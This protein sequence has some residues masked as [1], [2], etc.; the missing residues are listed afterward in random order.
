MDLRAVTGQLYLINGQR[1]T[2]DDPPGLLSLAPPSRAARGRHKDYLFIHLTLSG[3]AE[4]SKSLAEDLTDSISSRFYNA[5][6]SVTAALRKAIIETNELLL[7]QN[8]SGSGDN[9]EGA[10]IC[11]VLRENELFMAQTGEAF[12]MLGHDFGVERLPA[13]PP[14]RITPLGRTAGLDIRYYHNWLEPGDMLLLADPRIAHLPAEAFSEALI[15]NEVQSGLQNLYNKLEADTARLLLAGFTDEDPFGVPAEAPIFFIDDEDRIPSPAPPARRQLRK[16]DSPIDLPEFALADGARQGASKAVL[17]LGRFSGWLAN[18]FSKMMPTRDEIREDVD[19]NGWLMPALFATLIPVIVTAVVYGVYLRQGASAEINAIK[20][21]MDQAILAAADASDKVEAAGYYNQALNLAVE[22]EQYRENDPGIAR[23]RQ[24]ARQGLDQLE[25][26]TR[27]T[28]RTLYRF[29]EGVRLT[30]IVVPE[31]DSGEI[32]ILDAINNTVWLLNTANDYQELAEDSP[33]QILTTNQ[34]IGARAV[35]TIVDMSWRPTGSANDRDGIGIL[36]SL[37]S[38]FTFDSTLND[39]RAATLGLASQWVLPHAI[40]AFN[41]RLYV[42][43]Q[44]TQR[45]WR[46][47]PLGEG[48][49]IKSGQE[50][51]E[52]GETVPLSGVIDLSIYSEDGSVLLLYSDGRLRRVAS[53]RIAWDESELAEKGLLSPL[54]APTALKISGQGLNSSIFVSDPQRERIV[55]LSMAG[56][57]LAQF[58]AANEQGGESF[59][60]VADFVTL[61]NPFRIIAVGGR[62]VAIAGE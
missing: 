59:G 15:D 20:Q 9:R 17:G 16:S 22:A 46:Y 51:I 58:K 53:G 14:E 43:D 57:F 8:L 6:G 55:R 37:G 31:D 39:Y 45:I 54:T 48:F 25:D 3:P 23:S 19:S 18:F 47:F 56:I 33:Q 50:Y 1:Q 61:E 12:A 26:V 24:L 29:P 52:Y 32:Y 10:L 11:A 44:G 49:D 38:Y 42:L 2:D 28:A 5:S 7:R 40:T 35:G 34:A 30:S 13:K 41:E 60:N 27:M 4:E 36:D 21:E 62:E